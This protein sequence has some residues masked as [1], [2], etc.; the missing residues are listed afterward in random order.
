[1]GSVTGSPAG[2]WLNSIF[3]LVARKSIRSKANALDFNIIP[4]TNLTPEFP[5]DPWCTP[6]EQF[7]LWQWNRKMKNV[8]FM[9]QS[10]KKRPVRANRHFPHPLPCRICFHLAPAQLK[11]RGC[12]KKQGCHLPARCCLRKHG[13]KEQQTRYRNESRCFTA[14]DN[15]YRRQLEK[16]GKE[17]TI[18]LSKWKSTF[19]WQV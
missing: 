4:L 5:D 19:Y 18:T 10:K 6:W 17:R 11:P 8:D 9:D 7:C 2:A 12:E 15:N 1:M 16:Y 14:S 3:P 13:K